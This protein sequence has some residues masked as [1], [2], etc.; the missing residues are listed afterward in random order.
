MERRDG[1]RLDAVRTV[2]GGMRHERGVG[3]DAL[4]V[5]SADAHQNEYVPEMWRR[6]EWLTGFDGSAGDALVTRDGALL[7]TDGR[8]WT[9]AAAQ[10]EGTGV[11]LVRSG[12][13][14][15]PTMAAWLARE[16]SWRGRGGGVVGVDARVMTL[17]AF[18]DLSRRLERSGAALVALRENPVDAAWGERPAPPRAP[19]AAHPEALAGRSAAEKLADLRAAMRA[20]GATAHPIA[21]L[22]TIAWLFNLRGADVAHNPVFLAYALVTLEDATLFT[23]GAR[24]DAGALRALEGV[25]SLRGYDEFEDALREAAAAHAGKFWIDEAQASV[26]LATLVGG[27]GAIAERSRSAATLAKARKNAVE[28]AGMRSAH[29]RDGVALARFLLWLEGPGGAGGVTE[30]D[31]A[32]RLEALRSGGEGYAGTSFTTIAGYGANGAI[33]HYRAREGSA[34]EIGR[35]AL[36]L[37]D[38]GGQYRDGTTDVTRTVHLGAPS[39][40]DRRDCTLVLRA[41]IALASTRFPEGTSGVRLDALAR[42]PL[43]ALGLDYAHGTGHGVGAHLCV[44]ES[45]PSIGARAG[46]A[47]AA[48]VE[49][50]MVVSIE[51]GLYV[52][53]SHGVRIENLY[54]VERAAEG[55][56]RFDAL[57]MAPLQRSLID[58]SMLSAAEVAWVDAYHARVREALWDALDAPER[59]WLEAATR[60]LGDG[61]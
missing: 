30:F 13:R 39:A 60:A 25:A 41:H 46:A 47:S 29:V 16:T 11:A 43:W 1:S 6:R 57:T 53:G 52:E 7:W 56:L 55:W 23:D 3:V 5:P 32:S 40:Q 8:Y 12:A 26:W 31:A 17:R 35:D 59:A 44:H 15:A 10:L 54:L 14:G 2:M 50:G 45:P 36:L 24:V 34:R 58:V 27:G 4:I 22:D 48:P 19:V 49:E 42:A 38:S 33:V 37:V 61:A 51:P 20:A 18:E 21:E 9:Q 28:I